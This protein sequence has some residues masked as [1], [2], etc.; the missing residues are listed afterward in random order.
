[1]ALYPY[2]YRGA[3]WTAKA[4]DIF[5]CALLCEGAGSALETRARVAG[6][7]INRMRLTTKKSPICV[8]QTRRDKFLNFQLRIK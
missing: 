6:R 4:S 5:M 1:M 2:R 3:M 7:S 8:V